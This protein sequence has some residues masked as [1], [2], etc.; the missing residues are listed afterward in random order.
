M[1]SLARSWRSSPWLQHLQGSLEHAPAASACSAECCALPA[2]RRSRA[3]DIFDI[4]LQR[5]DGNRKRLE[6]ASGSARASTGCNHRPSGTSGGPCGPAGAIGGVCACVPGVGPGGLFRAPA[7][8]PVGRWEKGAPVLPEERARTK[9][10][11]PFSGHCVSACH[12]TLKVLEGSSR[13]RAENRLR[14]KPASNCHHRALSPHVGAWHRAGPAECYCSPS[15]SCARCVTSSASGRTYAAHSV[16]C[17]TDAAAVQPTASRWCDNSER[18]PEREP[19]CGPSHVP[20]PQPDSW[21][22]TRS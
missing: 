11:A 8:P 12:K 13:F 20:W 17:S 18:E 15:R 2:A 5:I 16:D 22:R 4:F 1:D 6:E 9:P 3:V 14:G 19:E 7:L 21:S 10:S